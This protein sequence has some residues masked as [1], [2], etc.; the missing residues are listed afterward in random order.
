MGNARFA[1]DRSSAGGEPIADG[2]SVL[3]LLDSLYV[4]AFDE[5]GRG[6][7]LLSFAFSTFA[8]GPSELEPSTV[9]REI[10]LPRLKNRTEVEWLRGVVLF[11]PAPV[12]RSLAMSTSAL[13]IDRG[14]AAARRVEKIAG[15]AT[16]LGSPADVAWTSRRL[17]VL[18]SFL[19]MVNALNADDLILQES[20]TFLTSPV[21]GVPLLRAG[22]IEVRSGHDD[23]QDRTRLVLSVRRLPPA[24]A[25]RRASGLSPA[26][27]R[28]RA[29]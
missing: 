2:E 3:V 4:G 8:R 27:I 6:E 28:R 21:E 9:L 22:R 17:D 24:A 1:Y 20:E 7:V 19:A 29:A 5:P 16:S 12:H 18:G 23:P 25:R 14:E 11:G 13:E 10:G 15:F 26:R